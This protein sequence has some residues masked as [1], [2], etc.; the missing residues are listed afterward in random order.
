MSKIAIKQHIDNL[1]Y[2]L[3]PLLPL[4]NSHMVDFFTK[5]LFITNVPQDIQQEINNIGI[6]KAI[7]S[8]FANCLQTNSAL[9]KMV[10]TSESMTLQNCE[11]VCLSTELFLDKMYQWGCSPIVKVKLESFMTAK[12]SHEVEFFSVIAA[13]I[14]KVSNTTHFIDLGDGKGYL[15]SFLSLQ[16]GIPVLGIDASNVNTCGAIKRVQK[17]SRIWRGISSNKTVPKKE[18]D[19]RIEYKSLYKQVTEFVDENVNLQKLITDNY[20]IDYEPIIG[21]VGLHTCGNLGPSSI[22][23]F[24]NTDNIKSMCNVG[25]CYHLITE[26]N[27]T[28][29]SEKCVGFPLSQY[30]KVKNVVIGRN[31]R[32]MANQSIDRILH[33]ET[34]PNITITYRALLQVVLEKHCKKLPIKTVGKFRKSPKN[35][36]EYCRIALKK[37]EVNDDNITDEEINNVYMEYIQQLKEVNFFYL[38]RCKLAPVIESLILLDRLLYLQEQ[39]WNNSFI[40]QL[41]NP[42]VSPRC[43]GIVALK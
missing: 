6:D 42:I 43:Y 1:L 32:M 21:L 33:N 22:R 10:E 39:G 26:K 40:V 29:C 25:C 16:H 27:E 9:R 38:L 5:S 8:F 35:F 15:S 18:E 24:S 2:F 34:L 3:E 19:F 28:D 7:S 36:L 11:D 13:S 12:K 23:L 31:A 17:L 20:D 30:L 14:F 37:I 4:A 41:F